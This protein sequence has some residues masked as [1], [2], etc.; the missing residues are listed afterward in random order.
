MKTI[1]KATL[2]TFISL[3]MATLF[4]N[5]QSN[6]QSKW[7]AGYQAGLGTMNVNLNKIAFTNQVFVNRKISKKIELEAG[8]GLT[9]QNQNY[10]DY[11]LT[12]FK[13]SYTAYNLTITAKYHFIQKNKWSLFIPLA[14]SN[15]YLDRKNTASGDY[16]SF[17]WMNFEES[18]TTFAYCISTGIGGNVNLSKHLY[19][20][21]QCNTG[22][23]R[24]KVFSD[25]NERKAF[26][27]NAISYGVQ[28]GIGYRF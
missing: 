7:S 2:L 10:I 24:Q 1:T 5:A 20:N 26:E 21:V 22:L 3:T 23:K 12:G 25:F 13:S 14:I 4:A 18:K 11:D 15:T 17:E 8:L 6:K 9:K 19:L 28:T 27:G 16:V